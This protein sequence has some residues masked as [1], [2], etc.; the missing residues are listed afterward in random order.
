MGASG[1]LWM[2]IPV[3]FWG[4]L[5]ALIAWA[6]VRIFPS[7]QVGSV[8]REGNAPSAEDILRERLARGEISAEEYRKRLQ[9]LRGGT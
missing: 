7:G 2:V 1:W 8:P 4:G 9:V 6:V 3:L 5:L